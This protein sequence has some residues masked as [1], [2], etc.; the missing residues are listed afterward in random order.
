MPFASKKL[1]STGALAIARSRG[2]G[3]IPGSVLPGAVDAITIFF[4]IV[5]MILINDGYVEM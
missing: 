4:L 5:L 1:W 2:R 3:I